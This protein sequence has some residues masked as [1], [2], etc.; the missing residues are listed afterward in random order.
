MALITIDNL[1]H[2]Y[3]ERGLA[4]VEA[5]R[6]ISLSIDQGEY[7]AVVG[8]NGSG[9]T[10][11]AL[12]L[13]G[14]LAPTSG[15]V[16]VDGL[17]TARNEHAGAIRS[18]VAMIF[19]SPLDQIVATVAEEDVAFGP[20]NLGV[21]SAELPALVRRSLERVGLWQERLRPPHLLSAGEQQ[22]LAIAGALAMSP[23]CLVLDEAASMLDPAGTA[24]LLDLLD[25]LN[26]AGITIVTVTHRMDEAARARRVVV[27]A[28][29]AVVD[30]GPP[31]RVLSR[32]DLARWG[33]EPLFTSRLAA[34]IRSRCPRLAGCPDDGLAQAVAALARGRPSGAPPAAG[35]PAAAP[36]RRDAVDIR[37]LRHVYLRGTPLEH[38]A[39]RGVNMGVGRGQAAALIGATGSGKSTL[40]Q[41][42]NGLLLA[43]AGSVR[44]LGEDPAAAGADLVALRRRVGLVFQRPEQQVFERY[45]GDDIAFGPRQAGLRG[46]DLKERVRWAMERVG[47]E[48]EAFKDR[49]T[50]AVSGG[51]R[52][53]IGLAGVLALEPALLALD[54]P[55][56]GLD[57][58]G[59]LLVLAMLQ[60]LHRGGTTLVVATHSMEEAAELADQ[61]AVLNRGSSVLAGEPASVFSRRDELARYGLAA[62]RALAFVERLGSLGVALD[63]SALS[64][65]LA[66]LADAVARAVCNGGCP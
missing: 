60:E 25:E 15:R 65:R 54:E 13:D 32:T 23:R 14:L 47:L 33:L 53:R 66:D 64:G 10:T 39:L 37:G 21:P 38:E 55:T 44:V 50:F 48:F 59:R 30:D 20:E 12:H 19:Q 17:D 7:V 56:S 28:A 27:L 24:G 9:K 61:V 16:L 3:S 40:L 1:R 29:G 42:L 4:P 41:H 35:E 45:V 31:A 6:G 8:A 57:P 63:R 51:E 2:T 18:R 43:Q 46:P 52:R 11:L 34:A 58:A 62:P 36:G 49:P 5:L 26:A 22:R